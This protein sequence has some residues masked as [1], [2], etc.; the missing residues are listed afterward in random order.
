MI[1]WAT[2]LKWLALGLMAASFSAS[3]QQQL[4][5]GKHY[6]RLKTPQAVES[7]NKIEVL[8]FFSY[9]CIHCY[10]LEE[11][12]GPWAKAAPADVSFK[13]IPVFQNEFAKIYFTLDALGRDDL[14]IKV[15]KA[16]HDANAKLQSDKNFF[17]WAGNNGLD[18]TKVKEL[19]NS[20]SVNSKVN[21]A[22]TVAQNYGIEA[23]PSVFV[24]GKYK[25]NYGQGMVEFKDTGAA[26]NSLIAKARSERNK[27]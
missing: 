21:R 26:I 10:H 6:V 8:E 3:A 18:A 1:R 9:G 22:K 12:L 11:F 13:R 20:F 24:D 16:I 17:D 19:W 14:S 25:L 2:A 27:K 7:G 5:E 23:T 15:F 4:T